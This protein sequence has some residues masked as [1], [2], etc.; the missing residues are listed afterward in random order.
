M[1]PFSPLVNHR[2]DA[3][4]PPPALVEEAQ[5]I[6]QSDLD[7]EAA[8][9]AFDRFAPQLRD[10][11]P[12]VRLFV[13]C[14]MMLEKQRQTE[15]MLMAWADL[16]S[17]FPTYPFIVRMLMRW[18]RRSRQIEEGLQRLHQ[19]TPNL[20]ADP[21]IADLRMTGYQELNAFAEIDRMMAEMLRNAPSERPLRVRYIQA[22]MKQGRF[23]EAAR[24]ARDL[25]NRDRLGPA[26]QAMIEEAEARARSLKLTEVEDVADVLGHV[27]GRFQ[28]RTPRTV[29]EGEIGPIMFFT[30][31]LGAG[32]AERQMTRLAAALQEQWDSGSPQIGPH[33]LLAPPMVCVRHATPASG[34]DFFLPVLQE[35][36]VKT[37]VL[38]DLPLPGVADLGELPHGIEDILPLLPEDL[39]HNT[40]KLVPLMRAAR[41]D[42]AY[43]WQ[44]GG[45]LTA[46]LA[47]LIAGVPS[48]VT[49]FRGLPPNL[50]PE[51]MRPQMPMLYRAL[52]RVP[53]V[54]FTANSQA[55]ARAYQDWL[56]LPDGFVQVIPN[57]VPQPDPTGSPEDRALW[58]TITEAS[59]GCTK[60]VLGIFR[61]DH[62][63]RPDLWVR[64]ALD[65]AARHADTRFVILGAGVEQLRCRQMI[66]AAGMAGRI[67]LPGPTRHVGFFLQR[68][69]LVMHLARFEGLPNVLIEAQLA[70]RPVLATPAGG[71]A[72]IVRH[73]E[74]GH[75]LTETLD[76]DPQEI[77]QALDF[78]LADRE[79]LLAMGNAAKD[80]S[81]QRFLTDR[82]L[83]S[84]LAI[85]EA[86]PRGDACACA[87]S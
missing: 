30:G 47:A 85:F 32:G 73:G 53:G 45:V 17:L 66:E 26:T 77:L 74:T 39:H 14:A 76:P 28:T 50:R 62:N 31:Q 3:L 65:H 19:I 55:T 18:Y 87:Q 58:Q 8:L 70:G 5:R 40:L 35:A 16:Q 52:A 69:D 83:A 84:T 78:L 63:K 34:A 23:L 56:G 59:P 71:T 61:F 6:G 51:L 72:E 82:I 43:L 2:S 9:A 57:A 44:D 79:R 12:D 46:A 36:R 80:H 33:R 86:A 20:L 29:V 24:I 81:R 10:H 75:I 60:T 25:G 13:A 4:P 64:V 15:G 7:P 42:T 38:A 21:A 49:S 41:I 67:F 22:L 68:A 48:I 27:V 1:R 11:A 54:R 37:C